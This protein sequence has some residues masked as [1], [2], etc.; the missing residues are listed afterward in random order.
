M[1]KIVFALIAGCLWFCAAAE[2]VSERVYVSTDK[3][4]YLAG[5]LVWC[6]VFCT[7]ASSGRLSG[8][9]AVA[10]IEISSSDGVLTTGKVS[11]I[12]GRGAGAIQI[13]LT[14]PTGN[15]AV[16][17]YT[18]SEFGRKD[19][20]SDARLVSVYNTFS[21]DRVKGGVEVASGSGLPALYSGKTAG[22]ISLAAP[23]SAGRSSS[24]TFDLNNHMQSGVTL[25]L[26]VSKEDGIHGPEP[27]SIAD[28]LAK[29]C[30]DFSGEPLDHE[31]ETFRGRLFGNDADAV[32]KDYSLLAVV[33]FPGYAEDVYAGKIA[34][35]GTVSFKTGNVHG[36]RDMVCEII[37]QD[38]TRECRLVV[39]SPFLNV[40]IPEI[41]SLILYKSQEDF[42]LQRHRAV[43]STFKPDADTLYEYLPKRSSLFLPDKLCKRY[44]LD[45]F[46]RFPTIRETLIE[47]TPDLRI[48]KGYDDR[49]QMQILMEGAVKDSREF[50]N[51]V[52]VLIDGVPVKDID[53]LLEFDPMLL[54]DIL[55]YPC[56]CSLGEMIFNGIVDFVTKQGDI[57]SFKFDRNVVIVDWQGESYPVAYTCNDMPEGGDD[58]RHTL[59]WHPLIELEA[60]AG[61]EIKVRTPSYP[62]TFRI[63]A[64]GL[65]KDGRPV[66]SEAVLE[67]R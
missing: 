56:S 55:V 44:H 18:A 62:G 11:M 65:S 41:P 15:Y 42:L 5:E 19:L 52:L 32:L 25:S 43:R 57:S 28:F 27:V 51:N 31:G 23:V 22:N 66:R 64:E 50:S 53:K 40:R 29:P 9:S 2:G 30:E 60:G 48:R 58:L 26:S 4:A 46:D 38:D 3:D 24:F 13:P 10:Y 1:K 54:S 67:V 61:K 16:L 14:A 7:E 39:E 63:V 35:D 37:G 36:N 12:A 17:G 47:I 21:T 34:P 49:T 6:S 45:D 59:Y 33:A 8:A 20:Q